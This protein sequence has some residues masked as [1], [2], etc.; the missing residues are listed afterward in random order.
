MK[1]LALTTNL[2]RP[3]AHLLRK[4]SEK[5][6][7][8]T[9]GLD[10]KSPF[11]DILVGTSIQKTYLTCNSRFDFRA[12]RQIRT[13]MHKGDFDIVHTFSSRTL[14]TALIASRG[15]K[16]KHITYRGT[17][18]H[19]SRID[20][21]AWLSFLNKRI[22]KIICVSD[23]VL[24]YL[25]KKGIPNERLVRIYKGH[26]PAWYL[27]AEKIDL[28]TVGIP[29][30]AL[31]VGCSANMRHIKG[32]DVLVEAFNKHLVGSGIH[33]LLIGEIRDN[34][35]AKLIES[36][37]SKS[38]LH[39]TGF[40]RDAPQLIGACSLFVMPSRG[41]EGFAKAVIEAMAQGVPAIVSAVGGLPEAVRNGVDGIVVKPDDSLVLA[42][43]IIK[44]IGNKDKLREF[45]LSSKERVRDYFNIE[46]TVE[47]TMSVYE[48]VLA[49]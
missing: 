10:E 14:S 13:L 31:V 41:R 20:P 24:N 29:K 15:F 32:V 8:L 39:C 7:S 19:L 49:S 3:E 30:G 22:S 27:N 2:D 12:I 16:A 23:A 21:A 18:G 42:Q 47:E 43:A 11:Q 35:L 17:S 26:D 1:V 5:G 46:R 36:S 33:L 40:R 4:I 37:P 48:A 25:L 34:N 44:A 6:V 38:F 9:L 45:G 28:E